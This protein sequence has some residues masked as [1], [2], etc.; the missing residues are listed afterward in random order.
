MEQALHIFC[1]HYFL[2][3]FLFSFF[4]TLKTTT[5]FCVTKWLVI[6]RINKT[7][8]NYI[9]FA[10]ASIAFI[11]YS[12]YCKNKITIIFDFG[13]CYEFSF[14]FLKPG[15]YLSVNRM[16]LLIV[17]ARRSCGFIWQTKCY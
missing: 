3:Y 15:L 2:A 6:T 14:Q 10:I 1:F 17:Q 8:L 5:T 16:Y 7:P 13:K 4:S 9:N 12:G 11:W